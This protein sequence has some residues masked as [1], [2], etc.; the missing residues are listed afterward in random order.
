MF[1]NRFLVILFILALK[2]E[3]Q[4]TSALNIADSLYNVGNYSEAISRYEEIIPKSP[5]LYLKI[6]RAHQ[7][8]GTLDDA[9]SNY[10]LAATSTDEA[11]AMNEYG[12]L[13]IATNHF[14]KAD[15]VF[16]QLIEQYPTNP[17]FYYQRGRAGEN[18]KPKLDSTVIDKDSIKPILA[19]RNAYIK[20]YE[21]AVELDS[22]HQKALYETALFYL[23][24][25]DYP[26]VEKLCMKA[27]ESYAD[28]VEVISV[29]AQNFYYRG[30]HDDAIPWFQK[31]LDLGQNTQFIHEK[32][33]MSYYKERM[34]ELA[35]EQYL[36]ALNFSPEDFYLHAILAKLYNYKAD[37]KEAQKHGQLAIFFKD[38]ALDEDYY[39]LANTYKIH[40]DWQKSMEYLN[41]A[42][43]ENPDLKDAI[44]AKAVVADNY[45]ADKEAVI[46]LYEHYLEKNDFEFEPRVK[47]TRSRIKILRQEL[48]MAAED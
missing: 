34:Y 1:M 36:E 44:Y 37:F 3:A 25:K 4:Q 26:L 30:F 31:L 22:T 47:L 20:D 17:N 46:K 21:K 24:K 38:M 6:A 33:G 5:S 10:K 9:L 27:L 42:L 15:S 28:N 41:L 32:L 19:A 18:I 12:K 29:L 11:I 39:T 16:T 8:K 35:I 43:E 7:A 2:A 48:F 14:K 40:K 23:K 45:Y 13:L